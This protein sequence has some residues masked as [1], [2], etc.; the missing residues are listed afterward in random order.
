[1][2]PHLQKMEASWPPA[3]R[4]ALGPVSL[5]RGD[6][7]G[8]RV[9][10]ATVGEGWTDGDLAAAAD[11]MRDMGQDALFMLTPD[12]TALDAR[13]AALGFA[14]KDPVVIY[15]APVA[16]VAGDGP[17]HMT[18]FPH[19]PPMQIARD[20]WAD[21]HVGPQRLAIMARATGAKAAILART[22]DRASGVA[23]VAVVQDMAFVHALHVV[24]GLRR[25]GAA[26][27]LMRAAAVFAA[28][29]GAAELVLAV[30]AANS[31]ARALYEGLGMAV[32]GGYHY[33]VLTQ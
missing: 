26:Q 25:Q 27:N 11:A 2:T 5:R 28:E 17:A 4:R 3:A 1:M 19:W 31:P 32:V 16:Q 13:L 8:Q 10:A 22:H 24:E 14:V 29:A 21:G 33:R 7:G 30:T 20:I 15:A 6:G 12:Q 9:C 23:Y 18:T